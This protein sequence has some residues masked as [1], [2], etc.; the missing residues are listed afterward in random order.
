MHT[1]CLASG[2]NTGQHDATRKDKKPNKGEIWGKMQF[3]PL[4]KTGIEMI[5][6]S[7]S[8]LRYHTSID[9]GWPPEEFGK[10]TP[11]HCRFCTQ[12]LKDKSVKRWQEP[13]SSA[14]THTS[15]T[16]ESGR[17]I[18]AIV[19]VSHQVYLVTVSKQL[20][21]PEDNSYFDHCSPLRFGVNKKHTVV[22]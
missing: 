21:L 1:F 5:H 12:R 14:N 2:S 6:F 4:R 13:A 10:K 15:G 18:I 3:N 22:N 7:V 19:L 8:I 16:K 9:N 17:A 20:K 11:R